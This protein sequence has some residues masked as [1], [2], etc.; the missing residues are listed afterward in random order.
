M[1]RAGGVG[2]GG[3][4]GGALAGLPADF[5][6]AMPLAAD[7]PSGYESTDRVADNGEDR[8]C[9]LA[10]GWLQPSKSSRT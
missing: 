6:Q 10:D 4:T 8:T 7:D 2:P 3:H 5:R 9:E 1:K